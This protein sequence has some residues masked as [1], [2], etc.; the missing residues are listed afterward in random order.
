[1]LA[2]KEMPEKWRKD[3]GLLLAQAAEQLPKNSVSIYSTDPNWFAV[4]VA[5]QKE[6][7]KQNETKTTASK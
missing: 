1:M 2:R 3:V 7:L 4:R 5:E 6:F